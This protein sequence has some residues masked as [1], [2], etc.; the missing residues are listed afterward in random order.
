MKLNI[1]F[2]STFIPVLGHFFHG[3]RFFRIGS[4]FLAET[5]LDAERGR[6]REKKPGS[7]KQIFSKGFAHFFVDDILHAAA[8][9]VLLKHQEVLTMGQFLTIL[10]P[11]L[12]SPGI[13]AM[14]LSSC[15][16]SSLYS[17]SLSSFSL[18][19]L[20]LYSFSLSFRYMPSCYLFFFS[21][22][23]FYRPIALVSTFSKI[24]EKFVSIKLTNHLEFNKLI[25]PNQFG[26][27]KEKKN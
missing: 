10:D 8:T 9:R 23:S 17:C 4:G 3:S 20:S 14:S 25:H 5:D 26:F 6:I 19:S 18:S 12:L 13:Y 7:E 22:S 21:H 2:Y 24:L 27:Q 11:V 16:L 15:S 1:F